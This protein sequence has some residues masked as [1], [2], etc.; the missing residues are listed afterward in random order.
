MCVWSGI[1]CR[2]LPLEDIIHLFKSQKS[3]IM[4]HGQWHLEK[5][6]IGLAMAFTYINSFAKQEHVPFLSLR[7]QLRWHESI[8]VPEWAGIYYPITASTRA[9]RQVWL[10]N[11]TFLH[12]CR[13]GWC[14]T[15]SIQPLL[16]PI[17]FLCPQGTSLSLASKSKYHGIF[18]ISYYLNPVWKILP[19]MWLESC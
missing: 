8:L 10:L 3:E 18:P 5:N 16:L 11:A 15:R 1:E 9:E 6:M 7:Q 12:L 4:R 2:T 13:H 14:C 19:E 17:L